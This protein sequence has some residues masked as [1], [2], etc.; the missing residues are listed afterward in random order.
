MLDA[1]PEGTVTVLFTDVEG[2]TELHVVRGDDAAAVMLAARDDL[3]RE[4]ISTHDGVAVKA[5]GDGLMAAF[6]SARKAVACAVATQ[7]ALTDYDSAHP[8]E[9]VRVRIGLNTGE[10]T[11]REGDLFG[12]AVSAAAR[13]AAKAQGGQILVPLVVRELAGVMPKVHFANRGRF[14]LKGFPERWQLF[15]VVWR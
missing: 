5:L 4:Q 3:I 1:L 14:R 11:R 7:R 6:S 15:E 9:P 8:D 10:V 2:S 13:V 12:A